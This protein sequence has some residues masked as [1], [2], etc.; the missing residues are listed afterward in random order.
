[1]ATPAGPKARS[2]CKQCMDAT[3]S[4][5]FAKGAK[6]VN[7]PCKDMKKNAFAMG[8]LMV[9]REVSPDW[10]TTLGYIPYVTPL[11]YT[12]QPE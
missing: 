9:M 12:P 4:D 3:T 6:D 1:M 11:G 10:V 5:G 8:P 7:R 2:N